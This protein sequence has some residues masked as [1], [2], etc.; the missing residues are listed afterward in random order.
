MGAT[1]EGGD[2]FFDRGFENPLDIVSF[3]YLYSLE[4]CSDSEMY[5][6]TYLSVP[7]VLNAFLEPSFS[8]LLFG[9][10]EACLSQSPTE[11]NL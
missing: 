8:S 5:V 4:V 3:K 2:C 9:P 10:N 11:L 6:V 1:Y 7:C